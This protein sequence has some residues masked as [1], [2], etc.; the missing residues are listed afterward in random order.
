MCDRWKDSFENFFSDMGGRPSKLHSIERVDTNGNYEPG[1]CKW[2]EIREQARNK[3]NNRWIEY[4]GLRMI[5]QDWADY[6]GA[7]QGN[8]SQ[9]IKAKGIERVYEFYLQKH[10]K[11]PASLPF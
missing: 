4:N 7:D 11:L 1:N 5:L 8:L 2:A 6:F 9:S 10:G 3:R